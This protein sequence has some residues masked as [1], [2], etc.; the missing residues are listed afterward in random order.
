MVLTL[1]KSLKQKL[2]N[3]QRG[4]GLEIVEREE[5]YMTNDQIHRYLEL[6]S[7]M[8]EIMLNSGINWK[9]EYAAELE[10][11]KAELYELRPLVDAAHKKRK[12]KK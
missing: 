4:G 3:N 5:N 12:E 11:I 2:I 6:S 10:S 9:P 7:R 1:P 8:L